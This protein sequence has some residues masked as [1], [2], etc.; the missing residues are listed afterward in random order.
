MQL[1]VSQA[2]N[3]LKCEVPENPG[4]SLGRERAA[5]ITSVTFSGEQCQHGEGNGVLT[6][7]QVRRSSARPRP[8]Q[9]SLLLDF[10]ASGFTLGGQVVQRSI[11]CKR[12]TETISKVS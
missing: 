1:L 11:T 2:F 8:N 6:H 10:W 7:G 3:I 9:V 4:N 5:Q 12:R